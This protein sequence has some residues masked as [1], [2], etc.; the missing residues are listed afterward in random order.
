MD[1]KAIFKAVQE[2]DEGEATRLL[3]ANA[4]RLERA[5]GEGARLLALAAM[6]GQLGVVKLL[7]Q[8][9]ASADAIQL[10]GK[11]ALQLAA[12]RGHAEV[13]AFLL[14]QGA[15]ADKRGAFA[16]TPLVLACLEGRM[17]VVRLLLQ[18]TGRQGLE[19]TDHEGCTAL[20]YAAKEGHGET[21][22]FLLKEGAPVNSRAANGKTPLV[23]ACVE[24][25]LGVVRLLL[26]HVGGQALQE[27]D[28]KGR[29]ALHWAALWG[30]GEVVALLLGQGAQANSRDASGETPFM[31]ACWKGRLAV[32]GMLLQHMGTQPLRET[33]NKGRTA[34]H[35]RLS[36]DMER[37][38]ACCWGK[39]QGQAAETPW[40]KRLSCWPVRRDT[41]QWWGCC[42]STWEDRH[43]RR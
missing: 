10:R 20:H 11:T 19:E 25:H 18:H 2:G 6:K 30:Q 43:Y 31:G 38:S 36:G 21:V 39:A 12:Q 26:R 37:L 15:Q 14:G 27:T 3:D 23:L 7:F 13:V 16:K 8:R 9:G 32:V 5:D 4:E 24:G 28:D 41:W 17:S 29:T 35:W 33:D 22:A 34:L 42:Y 40:A 1:M